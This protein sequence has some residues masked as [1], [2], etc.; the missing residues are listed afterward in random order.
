[1]ISKFTWKVYNQSFV[2]RQMAEG[3]EFFLFSRHLVTALN[4][5]PALS[6]D[7]QDPSFSLV[8]SALTLVSSNVALKYWMFVS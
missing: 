4:F 7:L 3:M 2:L 8:F 6:L 5:S 1:M